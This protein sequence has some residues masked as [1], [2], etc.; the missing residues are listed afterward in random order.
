M[1]YVMVIMMSLFLVA[2]TSY[3][4]DRNLQGVPVDNGTLE[5]MS[6]YR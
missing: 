5:G 3:Q 4:T 2:C 6:T 1:S